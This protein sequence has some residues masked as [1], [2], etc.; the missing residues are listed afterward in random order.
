MG[1]AS[2]SSFQ[3]YILGAPYVHGLEGHPTL[4]DIS[5]DRIDRGVGPR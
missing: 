3:R 4:F 1:D 5:R 2:R